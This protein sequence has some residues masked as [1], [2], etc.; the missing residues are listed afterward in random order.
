M[1]V[2][3]RSLLLVGLLLASLARAEDPTA[4]LQELVQRQQALQAKAAKT[5]AMVDMQEL[6]EPFQQLC[7][8]YEAYLKRYPTVAAGYTAYG[9]LLYK[10]P[11]EERKK[12]AALLL[13]SN[14]LD[15]NQPIV[16]N[17]LGN[18]LAEE[19]EP[20]RAINYFLAAVQIAPKE[21]LYHFQVGTLL[22]EAR[23]DFVKSGQWGRAAIDKSIHDAFEQAMILSPDN[24]PY[25][26][27]YG[28]CFY[29][30]ELPEWGDALKVWQALENKVKPGIERQTIRLHQANVLIKQEK[31][32][33]AR[34]VLDTVDEAVLLR[35]KN[36]L[37]ALL[38]SA[39]AK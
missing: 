19:G 10:P 11:I 31:F 23:D 16:K 21:P 38:P 15:P 13:K 2:F 25:A 30:L 6:R 5:D 28:E 17:Q 35:Q 1:N 7:N 29:D 39:A 12:A 37:V 18:Y 32:T 24:V 34:A 36:K 27:R 8:D 22:T 9:L 3:A 14:E 26:Y 33:E 4:E 20:L